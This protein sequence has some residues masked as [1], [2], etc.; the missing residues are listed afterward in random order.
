MRNGQEVQADITAGS[1]DE[2]LDLLRA[3]N[4]LVSSISDSGGRESR[5][6]PAATASFGARESRRQ[7]RPP[8]ASP[9]VSAESAVERLRRARATEK[10]HRVRGVFIATAF[11]LGAL[12]MGYAAPVVVVRCD[13]ASESVACTISERDLGIVAVRQQRLEH[14][15]TF[16]TET[17]TSTSRQIN[18][19]DRTY[20]QSRIVLS[21][22][23]GHSIQSTTWTSEGVLGS[24]VDSMRGRFDQFFHDPS[25]GR[26]WAW[27]VDWVPM[28]FAGLLGGLGL[29]MF[30]L[31]PLSFSRRG[32]DL[33][34][35][36][37]ETLAA[38]A[39]VMK[40]RNRRSNR[41]GS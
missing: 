26:W 35:A 23:E 20:L 1:K 22:G 28:L 14:T 41:P 24:S 13:R 18:K 29:L 6:E 11:L 9:A 38:F 36:G 10:P 37:A 15:T 30:A 27:Q 12:G 32:S 5:D 4:I 21:D 40:E 7:P 19:P 16:S 34:Y 3:Q 25:V 2:A 33:V 8:P 39:D 31:L 17:Q